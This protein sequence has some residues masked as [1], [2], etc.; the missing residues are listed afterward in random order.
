MNTNSKQAEGRLLFH[1]PPP[2]Y[3]Q[4]FGG[5]CMKNTVLFLEEL[6]LSALRFP[7]RTVTAWLLKELYQ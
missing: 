3:I 4:F 2:V 5:D 6:H 7:S 1:I